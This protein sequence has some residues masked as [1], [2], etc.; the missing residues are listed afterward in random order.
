MD[1]RKTA[2][3][4]VSFAISLA[5]LLWVLSGSELRELPGEIRSLHWGWVG[6]AVVADILVY[7]IQGW[8]W[9]SDGRGTFGIAE[10]DKPGENALGN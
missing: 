3:L 10:A 2:L 8:R 6:V 9:S 5:C 1:T 4:V 7:C